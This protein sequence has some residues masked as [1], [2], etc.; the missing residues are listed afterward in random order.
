MPERPPPAQSQALFEWLCER[1]G[2]KAWIERSGASIAY[3]GDLSRAF[4]GGRFLHIHRTGEEAAL[5]AR[6]HPVFRLA[7][8]LTYQ[9]P[10]GEPG[11]RDALARLGK[12]VDHVSK[13]LASRPPA[14]YFGLWWT[15][16][17]LAGFRALVEVDADQYHELR[18]ES[19]SASPEAALE[20][21]CRFL[22]LPDPTGSWR[23][24]AAKLLVSA[25][26][27]VRYDALSPQE[28]DEL[29]HA[30]APGNRLL[31]RR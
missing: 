21:A 15:E 11:D 19:L 20:Q 14:K 30:C 9:I 4:P 26:P 17:L 12:D 28:R 29:A 27:L 13:L 31:G 6:E 7:V 1:T 16:Q 22:A 25:E 3:V 23:S 24:E 2:R 10:L 18:F 5:S 8:M